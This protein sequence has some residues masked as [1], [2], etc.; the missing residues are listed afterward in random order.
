M[1]LTTIAPWILYAISAYGSIW[2]F[3]HINP[4]L[5][6]MAGCIVAYLVI[7]SLTTKS[8]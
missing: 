2:L 4:W 7:K 3:N 8:I 6:I 1:K 5:G